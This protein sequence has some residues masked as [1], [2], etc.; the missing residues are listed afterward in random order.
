MHRLSHKT[1]LI[2]FPTLLAA[3]FAANFACL[4]SAVAQSPTRPNVLVIMVDDM[5][6]SD[7]GCYGSE[8]E[9]PHLD[10][11]ADNG[12]RFS[13]FY[14]TAKC[15]SSRVS[16]LTGQYCIAAGDTTLSHAV[17]SAEVL[18][19]SGY[20]TAM[21]G[22]WHLKN[23]P[24]DFGF[25][26]YF[27]HLSGACNFFKGDNTF[28]LNG[29]PWKVPDKDFYTTVANVD[30][31]I[32]FLDE[33]RQSTKPWYLYVAFNAPHAP[34]HALPDDYAKYKGR[35]ESGWDVV[36]EA[37]FKKQQQLGLFPDGLTASPR[38]KHVKAWNDLLPWQQS[39]EANR[40]TTLAAMIDRVDQ[41]VGRL[42]ENLKSKDELENT[43]ILF[44]SD[45]GACPYDRRKPLLDVEPTNGDVSLAD[46]TG[47]SW[48][49]NTPFRY[50]KQ[51]QF[52]GGVSTPA[53]VHWP[54][55]IKARQGS[56]SHQPAHLIDVLPTIVDITDS[57]MPNKF[58]QRELR[59]VSGVSLR[60]VLDGETIAN[61]PPIHFLFS[62]DRGLRDGD[63][64]LV[65][66]QSKAWELYN[67]AK[68]RTELN[69]L[70]AAE[71]ERLQSMIRTWT[72]MSKNV[73]KAKPSAY[74]DVSDKTT[75]HRHREW[76]DYN[77]QSPDDFSR[78]KGKSTSSSNSSPTK[79]PKQIRAR[80]NTQMK[81]DGE[82]I[83]LQFTGD[84]PGIAM[85]LRNRDL[86]DG[87]YH[88]TFQLKGGSTDGG[89]VFYT[90]TQK[91][92]LPKGKRIGFPV[93]ADGNWQDISIKLPTSTRIHQ[94]RIDVCDG[95][96]Q[97][98]IKSLS[99]SGS[100]GKPLI[101]WPEKR[102]KSKAR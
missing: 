36:R 31:A 76:T 62:A 30:Y 55:G 29:Q 69:N 45:N 61:R 89:E 41:E 79:K 20:F 66:F 60:P 16:L 8:I 23:Q 40:M 17:T 39:Y 28:R 53:I 19:S 27:G 85:D 101:T 18:A 57:Q 73:L 44:V 51:N 75:P 99:L 59:P 1:R 33:A 84:D 81:I 3:I 21:T 15:H 48:A 50:Y 95:K 83:V 52:E 68:D 102:N 9:T 4:R 12:L 72:E 47:W 32:D 93:N 74:A 63:W 25:Q 35:Y 38:P 2:T 22:K 86:A 96:G 98:T 77:L 26:R 70:A 82:S 24:T 80:K 100:D 90:I 67:V 46:S 13:Q 7:L 78:G 97:A 94:L 88:L 10:S 43:M 92:T 54:A 64:K 58:A 42:V 56:I 14:N 71:P 5:G 11:L 37:R 91:N 87:P 65:S 34:L 49:R 6:Y